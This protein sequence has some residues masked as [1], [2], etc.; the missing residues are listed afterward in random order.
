[1]GIIPRKCIA[2]KGMKVQPVVELTLNLIRLEKKGNIV[3]HL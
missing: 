3:T 2:A 1:M